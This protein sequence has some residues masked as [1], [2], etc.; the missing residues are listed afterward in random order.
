MI[1]GIKLMRIEPCFMAL[2]PVYSENQ[3]QIR[4]DKIDNTPKINSYQS[5]GVDTFT[6]SKNKVN[7]EQIKNNDIFVNN[8]KSSD[9]KPQKAV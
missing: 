1:N 9:M 4:K 8:N 2:K 5:S 7:N 6:S 3:Q